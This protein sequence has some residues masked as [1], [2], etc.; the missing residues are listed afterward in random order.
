MSIGPEQFI[1]S[2][3]FYED[4]ANI[5]QMAANEKAQIFN[6]MRAGIIPATVA[7][8]EMDQIERLQE[9]AGNGWFNRYGPPPV[10]L[11]I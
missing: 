11:A 7:K 6:A 2:A 4:P 10:E 1:F 5:A 9:D 8:E 3:D